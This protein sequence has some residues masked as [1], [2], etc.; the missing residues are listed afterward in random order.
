MDLLECV[1][2]SATKLIQ[3]MGYLSYEDRLRELG[4]FSLE[5]RRLRGDLRQ[6]FQYLKGT[7][8]SAGSAVVAQREMVSNLKEG[9]FRLDIRKG[10]F[11]IRVVKHWHRLLREVVDALSLKTFKVR[12]DGALSNLI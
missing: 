8:S 7:G 5:K 4:L 11:M 10:F 6:A 2:R 1:Q 12:L 3:G 9:R